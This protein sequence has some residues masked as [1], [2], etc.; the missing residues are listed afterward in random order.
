M[1][2]SDLDQYSQLYK[3][4]K[5]WYEN[6]AQEKEKPEVSSQLVLRNEIYG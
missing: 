1:V 4:Q 6:S 2:F 3:L 5:L